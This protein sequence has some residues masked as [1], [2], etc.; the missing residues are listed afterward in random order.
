MKNLILH[1]WLKIKE[2]DIPV[3]FL[4]FQVMVLLALIVLMAI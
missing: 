2:I 1:N 3:R 4:F